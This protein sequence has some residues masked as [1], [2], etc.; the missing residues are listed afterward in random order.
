MPKK[1]KSFPKGS[2][3]KPCWELKYC[4]YGYLVEMFPLFNPEVEF[5]DIQK[6]F[7][8]VMQNFKNG[9]FNTDYEIWEAAERLI[10][11]SPGTWELLEHY[12]PNELG[13]QAWGHCCPVFWAQSGA[14]ETRLGR[15]EGR[16]IPREVMLKVVRRDNHICQVCHKHV[17]DNEIEFDHLIPFSKGGPT[18]VENIRLL[19][20]TCNRK[21]SNALHELLEK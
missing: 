8:E 20:R 21:K 15:R 18:T 13:C 4:P 9:K 16:F 6:A 11:F 17:P 7:E 12:D 2:V 14:T 19:C 5:S 3:C 1:K 10:Y